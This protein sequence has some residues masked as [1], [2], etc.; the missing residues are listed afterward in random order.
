MGWCAIRADL[1]CWYAWTGYHSFWSIDARRLSA[2]T[3]TE[4]VAAKA[5]DRIPPILHNIHGDGHSWRDNSI[6]KEKVFDVNGRIGRGSSD[7]WEVTKGKLNKA[8]EDGLLK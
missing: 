1:V 4:H 7:V 2:H 3:P 5:V 6:S 8:V